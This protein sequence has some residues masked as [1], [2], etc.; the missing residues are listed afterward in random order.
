M[1]D[2]SHGPEA[3]FRR[4]GYA[5]EREQQRSNR[6]VADMFPEGSAD[7]GDGQTTG[8]GA[9]SRVEA[10]G[11]ELARSAM[12]L[13]FAVVLCVIATLRERNDA[14][15]RVSEA[16]ARI[17]ECQTEQTR[18]GHKWKEQGAAWKAQ[19]DECLGVARECVEQLRALTVAP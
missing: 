16:N 8:G 5:A 19:S 17:K 14:N 7:G 13:L 15:A 6:A 2:H 4:W 3:A 10:W 11:W 12:W 1:T 18:E 9:M